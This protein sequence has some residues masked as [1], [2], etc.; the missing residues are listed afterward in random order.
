MNLPEERTVL[1]F[2]EPGKVETRLEPIPKLVAG[3]LAVQTEVSAIS[4]GTEMLIYR[5]Q[6]PA[7]LAADESLPSLE[8]D[9]SYP[10]KYGY[11]CVGRIAAV[12]SQKLASWVGRRVFS[13]QPHQSAF[14][15]S[16]EQ[17]IPIGEDIFSESTVFL[18]NLETAVNLVHDGEPRL[19]ERVVIFGQGIVGLLTSALLA[20]FPL[21]QLITLDR[22]ELRRQ[23]SLEAGAYT[24]LDPLAVDTTEILRQKLVGEQPGADLVYELS[25]TP[26]ALNQAIETTGFDGRIIV[27][28]WYGTKRAALD[29]GGRFHRQR[30]RL[31]SSQVSTISPGLRGRW[32]KYRRLAVALEQLNVIQPERWI[33]HRFPIEQAQ[34]AYSL[35][36]EH[37]DKTIQVLLTY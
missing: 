35:I 7:E 25:G 3:E 1:Y 27:G 8:G 12:G 10:L 20:K 14:H 9:L 36:D 22:H 31:I 4:P 26:Q 13:F 15:A 32:T 34:E 18:P 2:T 21:E 19:G 30:I 37:P 6:A 28:S 24:S 11:A 23:A 5:G 33:T 17:L 16:P 29:L